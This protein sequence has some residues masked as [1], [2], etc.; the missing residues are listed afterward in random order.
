MV[1][2]DDVYGLLG[3][4]WW[5]HLWY[6]HVHIFPQEKDSCQLLFSESP[7]RVS[8][9]E[10]AKTIKQES[11]IPSSVTLFCVDHIHVWLYIGRKL[12]WNLFWQ[13]QQGRTNLQ[14]QHIRTLQFAYFPNV[15]GYS[16]K[17]CPFVLHV[18]HMCKMADIVQCWVHVICTCLLYFSV[19]WH[20]L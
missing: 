8:L 17:I 7:T 11:N 12:E 5:G 20:I 1:T 16:G 14:D 3:C 9:L 6:K 15:N 18:A 4:T 19:I 13:I 10:W 2:Y